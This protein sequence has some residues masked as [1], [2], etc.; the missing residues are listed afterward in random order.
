MPPKRSS[1]SQ[2]KTQLVEVTRSK[3]GHSWRAPKSLKNFKKLKRVEIQ[4]L[5]SKSKALYEKY[6][7][8]FIALQISKPLVTTIK[9]KQAKQPRKKTG[10][11]AS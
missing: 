11:R 10:H 5:C 7:D 1:Q 4:G 3:P 2:S 8:R 6:R 9:K